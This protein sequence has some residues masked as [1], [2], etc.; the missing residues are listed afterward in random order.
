[1]KQVWYLLLILLFTGCGVTSTH[2]SVGE[3]V[4][5]EDENPMAAVDSMTNI[6]HRYPDTPLKFYYEC[7]IARLL[8]IEAFS[9]CWEENL[10]RKAFHYAHSAFTSE[11]DGDTLWIPALLGGIAS[12]IL[13]D[14]ESFQAMVEVLKSMTHKPREVQILLSVT[15]D[16]YYLWWLENPFQE[17][18]ILSLLQEVSFE[19]FPR[20]VKVGFGGLL[21]VKHRI[22]HAVLPISVFELYNPR[23]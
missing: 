21:A 20:C 14:P 3:I 22:W 16:P 17:E 10:I 2:M 12:L 6:L 8:L 15:E 23:R 11:K 19:G 9:S 7:D 13:D 18:I 5:L 4:D 1:M